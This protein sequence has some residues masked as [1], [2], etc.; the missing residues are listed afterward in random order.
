MATETLKKVL[1][2]LIRD[3]VREEL[4]E[5]GFEHRLQVLELT[6]QGY[7]KALKEL[8]DRVVKLERVE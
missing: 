3:V 5:S 1:V 6:N 4:Q 2:E 8:V 7:D